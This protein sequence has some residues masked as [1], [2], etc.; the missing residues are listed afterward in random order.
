MQ[1]PSRSITVDIPAWVDTVVAWDQPYHSDEE[2]ITL[3]IDL[4]LANIQH[5]TGGPFGAAVFDGPSGRVLGV[6][7]NRV[8]PLNNSTLHAEM[9]ALMLAEQ[10][11][12]SFSL[13][14]KQAERE[15]FASCEPC[16]MCLGAVLWSG[17]KRLAWAG[18]GEDARALGFDEGPVF[19][20]SYKY[21]QRAG[22]R[23]VPN[24]QREAAQKVFQ[25]YV[26]AGGLV[27]NG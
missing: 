11:L 26:Q 20:E 16:A 18:S 3:T 5:G 1:P 17:V 21:L 22:I 14:T 10:A 12:A 19:P 2:K 25:A 7:V 4:A 9:L 24:I 27:Y 13:A 23:L 6:G 8:V 15:L